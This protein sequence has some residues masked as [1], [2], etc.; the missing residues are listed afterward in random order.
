[1]TLGKSISLGIPITLIEKIQ[2]IILHNHVL[3]FQQEKCCGCISRERYSRPSAGALTSDE[4]RAH[5]L[6]SHQTRQHLGG[7]GDEAEC[8]CC[9]G[10]RV[11]PPRLLRHVVILRKT[12]L[13]KHQEQLCS[14]LR[15]ARR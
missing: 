14:Y 1:M 8:E 6:L 7:G 15:T 4:H 10:L 13:R 11:P 2:Y 3:C 9:H 5:E 12:L